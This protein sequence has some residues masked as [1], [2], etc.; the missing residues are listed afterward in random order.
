MR[1]AIWRTVAGL[2]L[3]LLGVPGVTATPA[4]LPAFPGAE[5]FGAVAS[6]GR[7]GTVYHVITLADAGPGSF[8]DAVDAFKLT[9]TGYSQLEVYLH[10]LVPPPTVR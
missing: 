3:V 9:P 5:G 7:G 8:R 6:G 2:A 1:P 10:G 4:P